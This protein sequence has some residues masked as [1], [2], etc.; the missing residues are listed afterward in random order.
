MQSQS[1]PIINHYVALIKIKSLND[2]LALVEEIA[3][4]IITGLDLKVVERVSHLFYPRGI[5]LAYILSE[6]HLLIHS[7]P[8]FGTIHIDLVTCSYRSMK[9]FEDTLKLAFPNNVDYIKTKSVN[10]DDEK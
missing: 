8:E 4:K 2:S 6:S 9:K 7:W 10:F 3:R 1:T 5:T